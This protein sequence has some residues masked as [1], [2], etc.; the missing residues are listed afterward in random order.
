M[1][2]LTRD[3]LVLRVCP[4]CGEHLYRG[5]VYSVEPVRRPARDSETRFRTQGDAYL[6]LVCDRWF[7]PPDRQPWSDQ[8][9]ADLEERRR[10]APDRAKRSLT[11]EL[12]LSDLSP[13]DVVD[14]G[15]EYWI[16][17]GESDFRCKKC[18]RLPCNIQGPCDR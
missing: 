15:H 8:V 1:T 9:E 7:A 16:P 6:C 13:Q 18:G 11:Q 2:K 12:G 3:E 5:V 4:S 14:W 10:K 17:A